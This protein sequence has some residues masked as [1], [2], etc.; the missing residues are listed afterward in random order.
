MDIIQ[1]KMQKLLYA[2][3]LLI[4]SCI[5]FYNHKKIYQFL[6][7]NLP[8]RKLIILDMNGLIVD[9]KNKKSFKIDELDV[10]PSSTSGTC[11]IWKRPYSD[12]FIDFILKN[13]DVAVWSSAKLHNVQSMVDFV[14]EDRQKELVFI[15]D[16]TKCIPENME[17]STHPLFL[18]PID[19]V[20][21]FFPEYKDGILFIDDTPNK[22]KYNEKFTSICPSTW[23]YHQIDDDIMNINGKLIVYL[24]NILV[25]KYPSVQEHVKNNEY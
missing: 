7:Q 5:F 17:G 3:P 23:E 2:T 9:K 24:N 12:I 10:R 18:K 8:R 6:H 21:K 1:F 11:F 16:Q 25:S 4:S 22:L 15:W 13:F 19:E 20:L 14:F